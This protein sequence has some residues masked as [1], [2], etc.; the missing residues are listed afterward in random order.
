MRLEGREFHEE[1][2][3]EQNPEE[4]RM[5]KAEGVERELFIETTELLLEREEEIHLR[6]LSQEFQEVSS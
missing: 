5:G 3:H 6:H 4:H 1:E 2:N